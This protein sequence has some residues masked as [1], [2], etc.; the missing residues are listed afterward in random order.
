MFESTFLSNLKPPLSVGAFDRATLLKPKGANQRETLLA[1]LL[2]GAMA[3]GQ[4]SPSMPSREEIT[5]LVNKANEKTIAYENAV[6]SAKPHLDKINPQF[7]K[8][9][10][11]AA[12]T[13]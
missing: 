7:V 2:L 4:A 1:V 10:L 5:E 8:D 6:K 13:P 12:S 3:C 9:Y 11:E